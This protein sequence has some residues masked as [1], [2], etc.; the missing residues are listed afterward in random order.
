M[1]DDAEAAT[2]AAAAEGGPPRTV[3][4]GADDTKWK[5]FNA[6]DAARLRQVDVRAAL[7]KA[8]S[9]AMAANAEAF[10]AAMGQVDPA[11]ITQLQGLGL[12]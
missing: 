4:G 1:F 9:S 2:K 12:S 8:L 5:Q 10:Q 7:G 3:S 11:L 6:H